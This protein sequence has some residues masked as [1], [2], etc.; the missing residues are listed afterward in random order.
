MKQRSKQAATNECNS[1][2][3]D[4]FPQG[5]YPPHT[6]AMTA[7]MEELRVIVANPVVEAA[8]NDAIAHLDPF[9]QELGT[10][11]ENPWMGTTVDDFVCYFNKWFTFLPQPSSGLGFIVPLTFFYRTTRRRFTS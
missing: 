9:V 8:Y 11:Q 10:Q 4:M 5:Y 7:I 1:K 2:L 6:P 3:T